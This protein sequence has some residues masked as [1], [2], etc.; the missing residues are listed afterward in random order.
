[1]IPFHT[2]FFHGLYSDKNLLFGIVTANASGTQQPWEG[3]S[4][5]RLGLVAGRTRLWELNMK[6]TRSILAVGSITVIA[7]GGVNKLEL[8]LSSFADIRFWRDKHL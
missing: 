8:H 1:V 5:K 2:K 3:C 6:R 7:L 4:G